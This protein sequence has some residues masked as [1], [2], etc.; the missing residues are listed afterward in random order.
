MVGRFKLND[1]EKELSGK[2]AKLL[3]ESIPD[4]NKGKTASSSSKILFDKNEFD[5]Y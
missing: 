5:K 2:A 3:E 1:A 4:G